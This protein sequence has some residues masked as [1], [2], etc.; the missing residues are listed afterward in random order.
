MTDRFQLETDITNFHG[1]AD[2]IDLVC[3][4]ILEHDMS[5]DSIVNALSGISTLLRLRSDKAFETFVTVFKLDG[6][7]TN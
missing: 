4:A 1:V 6:S 2:D 7:N 5:V 3:E